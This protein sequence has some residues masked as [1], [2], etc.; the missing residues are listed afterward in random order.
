LIAIIV[1][2]ATM[3]GLIWHV[4]QRQAAADTRA[5]AAA[6]QAETERQGFCAI[7][8]LI[9]NV[10][11]GVLTARSDYHCGAP[12]TPTVYVGKP[13]PPPAPRVVVKVPPGRHAKVKVIRSP[14]PG[15]VR[16]VTARPHRHR[17]RTHR[18]RPAP[19]GRRRV[20]PG[21]AK[22]HRGGR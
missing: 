1:I 4:M 22:K 2:A 18:A 13:T 8:A 7:L 20:P 21:Q 19:T 11:P 3:L 5:R 10:S 9:P 12:G 15:P 16:T 14:V 17:A 6:A